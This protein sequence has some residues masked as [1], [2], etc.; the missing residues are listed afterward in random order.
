MVWSIFKKYLFK[1]NQNKN[2]DF[3][4]SKVFCMMPWVHFHV[5]QQGTVTPCCQAPWQLE[6]A[7]G[8]INSSTISE[9]W[10]ST[11]IR[12]F[13]KNLY[14]GKLDSRC[15]SCHF[16]EKSGFT[17]LRQITNHNYQH[18]LKEAVESSKNNFKT[19]HPPVYFDIRFSNVCNL[20]CR[21]CGPWSSSSWYNDG[22]A[23]GMVNAQNSPITKAFKSTTAFFN[24]LEQMIDSLEELYF[25]GG[26]P[27]VIDEH[28]QLLELLIRKNKTNV[29]LTYNTNFSSFKYKHYNIIELWKKFPKIS[30]AASLDASGARGEL[31]RKNLKWE[32]VIKNRKIL[33]E[34]LPHVEFLISPTINCYNVFHLPD[35]HKEWVNLN[36]IKVEDFIPTLLVKPIE[37]NITTLPLEVK[38]NV[39]CKYEEHLKWIQSIRFVYEVKYQHM[40]KQFQNVIRLLEVDNE[41]TMTSKFNEHYADLDKLRNEETTLVFPELL[42]LTK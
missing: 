33:L 25:A 15:A 20:R 22:V 21:I 26:E 11:K 41:T 19:L 5:T 16:R 8:E 12:S 6:A 32:E 17:S 36:L 13:R 29:K 30:I 38:L 31:L 9:I 40:L 7:F 37:L 42:N 2:P 1:L 24:E 27:L 14:E 10:N 23:L 3:T 4:K 34:E 28:Y 35:F 39:R 18:K